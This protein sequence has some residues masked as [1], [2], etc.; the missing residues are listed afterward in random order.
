MLVLQAFKG[1]LGGVAQGNLDLRQVNSEL[2]LH[3]ALTKC[4]IASSSK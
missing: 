1:C 3:L 2:A 4:L